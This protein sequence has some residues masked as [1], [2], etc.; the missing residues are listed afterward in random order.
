MLK[1]YKELI[2][3]QKGIELVKEVY[4]ATTKLP[5]HELYGLSSQMR[6]SSI[7]I[8]SNIAEGHKRKNI[9]EFLQFLRISYGSA[10]ELETQIIILQELYP[11]IDVAKLLDLIEEIQKIL[12]SILKKLEA[13]S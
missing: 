13:K 8:P 11:N 9:K 2:V 10:A 1:S 3:W 4:I 12:N 6:R 5:Q 7:S